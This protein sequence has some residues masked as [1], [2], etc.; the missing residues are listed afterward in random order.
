MVWSCLNVENMITVLTRK[1]VLKLV[2]LVQVHYLSATTR[3]RIS[4]SNTCMFEDNSVS[5]RLTRASQVY[6]LLYR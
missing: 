2:F 5:D 4:L 3:R 6:L 1:V